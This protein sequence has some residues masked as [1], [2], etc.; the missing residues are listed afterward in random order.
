MTA[1]AE[2]VD[3]RTVEQ[4]HLARCLLGDVP[5]VG[6]QHDG[7]PGACSSRN[8]A[9]IAAPV[10]LSRLPVGSSARMIAGSPTSA[11]AMPTRWRSPPESA[12]GLRAALSPRPTRS[13]AVRARAMR[14]D[15]PTPA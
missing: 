11:L 9:T 14:V 3:D 1:R 7:V 2:V 4:R 13:R 10:R 15:R 8:R 5:V 6:D 12:P